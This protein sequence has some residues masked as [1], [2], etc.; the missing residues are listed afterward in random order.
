MGETLCT[1]STAMRCIG[2]LN[3]ERELLAPDNPAVVGEAF[4]ADLLRAAAFAHGVDQ[5]DGVLDDGLRHYYN[6]SC[7]RLPLLGA[8]PVLE[9]SWRQVG[10][11][12]VFHMGRDA[13]REVHNPLFERR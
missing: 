8:Q 9:R 7:Q 10:N 3:Y 5:L 1:L 4:A 12:V 2:L 11:W 6:R 13:A